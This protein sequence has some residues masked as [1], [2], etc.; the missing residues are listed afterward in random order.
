MTKL[1]ELRDELGKLDM[2]VRDRLRDLEQEYRSWQLGIAIPLGEDF[3]FAKLNHEWR[4][5]CADG[6]PVT[7][8]KR[9]DR[10]AFLAVWGVRE[11]VEEAAELALRAAIK[12]RKDM[13][14]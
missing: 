6:T 8:T 7:D 3:M 11:N 4:F 10:A 1:K 14:D 9:N 5:L 2:A 13:L 12:R